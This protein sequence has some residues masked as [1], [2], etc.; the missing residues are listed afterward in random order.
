M[1][2]DHITVHIAFVIPYFYPALGYGGTPRLAYEMA[3]ALTRRGHQLMVLTT[4]AG[5]PERISASYIQEAQHRDVDGMQVHYYRNLSNGLAHRHRI[6]FPLAALQDIRHR[7]SEA[8]IIHVHDLRSFLSVAAHRA[9]RSLR[10][11]YVLSPHGGLPRMGK[12]TAKAVF[13]FLWGKAILRDAAAVCV[14]S[15]LEAKD[16]AA[17]GVNLSRIH[18]LPAAID[19]NQYASLTCRGVFASRWGIQNRR[20]VLFLGRLHW[21]KGADILIEA[22][23]RIQRLSD[24]HLVI[25]GADD[26]AEHQLKSLVKLKRL[27]QSVTFT[28]FLDATE[29]A[30]ALRDSSVVVLPSR[31]EAF[32]L[33]ALE[34]LATQTPVILTSASDLGTWMQGHPGLISFRSEDAEDLA[35]KLTG[36][37]CAPPDPK[38]MA[39]A[40]NF[41]LR[42]FSSDAIAERAERLYQSLRL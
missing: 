23:S 25:A 22:M 10:T 33:T 40:R 2:C 36:I 27:E 15:P 4:D 28:G 29:K 32:P 1:V 26:G 11:P 3:R 31:R 17:A 42:E 14:V 6:F 21:I 41:V 16:A 7:L 37:L 30:N 5:G 13:D 38:A 39:E 19:A 20:I 8:E 34:A 12:A 24:V 18:P 35:Q 9:A